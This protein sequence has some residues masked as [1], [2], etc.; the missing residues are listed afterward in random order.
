MGSMLAI[1][2]GALLFG[3]IRLAEPAS[4]PYIKVG[5][6]D[7][8]SVEFA[9]GVPEMQ[10]LV[11]SYAGQA[12]QLAHQGARIVLMPEKTGLL[13]NR[14]TTIIDL[15]LQTVA[16]STGATLIIGVQHVVA[17]DSFNEARIYRPDQPVVTY[18][19]EHLLRP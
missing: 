4:H 13:L 14:D 7:T 10:E 11:T 16:D 12:Q 3:A 2:A 17:R 5:L 1:L 6:V 9:E 19:K 15:I 8:D 18:N